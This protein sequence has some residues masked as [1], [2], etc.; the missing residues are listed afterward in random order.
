MRNSMC[1]LEL[2]CLGLSVSLLLSSD[3]ILVKLF[4]FFVF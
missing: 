3:V 4:M 2:E 1:S